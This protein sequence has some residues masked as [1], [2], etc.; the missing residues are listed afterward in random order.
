MQNAPEEVMQAARARFEEWDLPKLSQNEQIEKFQAELVPLLVNA[1]L[2]G[3]VVDIILVAE[4]LH[5]ALTATIQGPWIADTLKG[6][7]NPE[8]LKQWAE[9]KEFRD[10]IGLA[11]TRIPVQPL[12]VEELVVEDPSVVTPG[13]Q[14]IRVTTRSMRIRGQVEG[15][16]RSTGL[17]Q[18]L[19]SKGVVVE[20]NYSEKRIL[21]FFAAMNELA[22]IQSQQLRPATLQPQDLN[23]ARG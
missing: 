21:F 8:L 9:D 4:E 5:P 17:Q 22:M 20:P 16:Y 11:I 6:D 3:D 12:K 13:D 18:H 14:F 15:W 10:A 7:A 1:Y 2:N 19:F 23:L